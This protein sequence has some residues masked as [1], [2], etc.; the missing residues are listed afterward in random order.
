V[1]ELRGQRLISKQQA[2]KGTWRP[3]EKEEEAP[4]KSPR[5]RSIPM[6]GE[7]RLANYRLP[8]ELLLELERVAKTRGVTMTAIVEEAILEKLA[9][10]CESCGR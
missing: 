7:R 6:G 2:E 4:R 9:A 5:G 1:G 8:D 10:T 3:A